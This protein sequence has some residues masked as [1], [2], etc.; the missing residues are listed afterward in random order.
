MDD[1]SET[2]TANIPGGLTK[3]LL[4]V[5]HVVAES[6]VLLNGAL[7]TQRRSIAQLSEQ[8]MQTTAKLVYEIRVDEKA[9][10][11]VDLDAQKSAIEQAIVQSPAPADLPKQAPACGPDTTTDNLSDAVTAL[12]HAYENAVNSQQQLS[13]LAEASL[14]QGISILYASVSQALGN[15]DTETAAAEQ[16]RGRE[17]KS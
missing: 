9:F 10:S 15:A 8:L 4:E 13:V 5:S 16:S 12:I 1:S 11:G 6:L 7:D 2:G 17:S 14:T 3:D